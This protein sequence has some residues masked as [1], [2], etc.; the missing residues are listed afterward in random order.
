[1]GC[2]KMGVR[3]PVR[4]PLQ[5]PPV[6]TKGTYRDP[7]LHVAPLPCWM[8]RVNLKHQNTHIILANHAID[9]CNIALS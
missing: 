3:V 2:W 4:H 7:D 1:V 9:E 6:S 5:Q 8:A